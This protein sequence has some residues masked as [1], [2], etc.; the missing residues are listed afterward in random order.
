V[1]D[2]S[3]NNISGT[4]PSC[5]MNM[6]QTLVVL[7]LRMNNLIGT[8]PDMF[9]PSCGLRTL[10]LQK[11]N[12]DGQI[13]ISLV[14]CSALE[15]LDLSNNNIVDRFPCLLKKISTLRVL[16]L[17]KNKFYGPI[18]CPATDDTWHMLQIIDLSFNN[19]SGKL[20][21]QF[22]KRWEAMMSDNDQIESK[23]NHIQFPVFKYGQIYYQDSVTVTSKGQQMELVRIMT[24]YTTVDLSSNLFEGTIP[25]VLMDFNA[26][27]VLNFSNNRLSGEIPSSI[28]NM[29]QLESLDLSNNSFDGEIPVQLERLHFLSYLNLSYNHF[30]GKIPTG[31]QLQS[32][33]ASSFEGNDGLYGPPLTEIPDGKRQDEL[34][35]QLSCGRLACSIDW[36]FLS[37]ELGMVFGLG[38][39][40]GPLM[41]WKKWR[42]KYWKLVDKIICWMFSRMH[43]EYVTDRG[44]TYIVL[45]RH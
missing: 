21:G 8:I 45:R 15:V 18:K 4:I 27:Y 37:V 14:K 19:F 17:R 2:I 24:I 6:T 13:P 32:F 25:N 42:I 9:P 16:V 28:G 22:F 39:V 30:K 43:L 40:I 12:L 5:L 23:V 41:F 38:I 44:Q 20:P 29:K 34:H 26:L 10:D 33:S 35:P 31:T 1:L 7:N 11:N 3:F 36:N